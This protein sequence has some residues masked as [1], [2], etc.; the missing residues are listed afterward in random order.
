[1]LPFIHSNESENS[2][3]WS[4]ILRDLKAVKAVEVMEGEKTYMLRTT[5][6]GCAG[7]IFHAVGVAPPP[8]LMS[9]QG[10]HGATPCVMP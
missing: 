1:M 6:Q 2:Y 9:E 8:S 4:D 5:L 3:E 7:K 10:I